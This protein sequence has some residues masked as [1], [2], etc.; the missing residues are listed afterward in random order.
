MHSYIHINIKEGRNLV[1]KDPNGASDPYIKVNVPQTFPSSKSV[2]VKSKYIPETLNPVW[3]FVIT[4]Y[5]G[6]TLQK[7]NSL[8]TLKVNFVVRRLV[9]KY[10]GRNLG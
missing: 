2:S 8:P 9:I 3:N 6:I 7:V 1:A 10:V 4:C 5:S